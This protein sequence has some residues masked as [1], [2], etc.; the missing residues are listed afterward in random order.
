VL[1]RRRPA[2][3]PRIVSGVRRAAPLLALWPLPLLLRPDAFAGQPLILCIVLAACVVGLEACLRFGGA[4]VWGDLERR[5]GPA[6]GRLAPRLVA[7]AA[8]LATFVFGYA[9]AVRVHHKLLTSNFDF[10]LFENLFYNTL[11]GRHGIALA[12]P[13]FS[14][15]AEFLIYALLPFYAL[16]PRSETLFF[17]QSLLIVG[18][19]VPLYLL[20]ERWL[21]SAWSA[22]LLAL[23]YVSSP[24]LHGP[25][26]FDFHFLPLSAF[27]VLW[28]A[29]FWTRRRWLAFWPMVLLALCCREDVAIGVAAVG[30]GLALCGRTRRTAY[31]LLSLGVVWFGVVKFVWMPR[32]GPTSFSDYYALLIPPGEQ[33]FGAVVKT[34][35][36]NPLYTLSRT[37][38][39]DKLLLLLQLCAPLAFLPLRQWG[40]LFLLVPGTI[41][42]GLS[43][44]QVAI[45][46]IQF[47]YATHFL[48]YVFIAAV[49]GLAA[50]APR[51]RRVLWPPMLLGALVITLHFGAFFAPTFKTSFHELSFDYGPADVERRANFDALAAQIPERARLS[52]GEYEGAQL[53]RRPWLISI[54][55]GIFDADY[56]F[57]S[58]RSLRWGG[59]EGIR[60]ALGS[61]KYGVVGARGDLTLLA[62]GADTAHNPQAQRALIGFR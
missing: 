40:T 7:G 2:S 17:L 56:V 13:Y 31:A 34:L 59:A 33:G 35:L 27:F 16:V 36:S 53:A 22:A 49:L 51:E 29:W 62:R 25:L 9:R 28:A 50:R 43:T 52:S 19:A 3:A 10:G 38:S 42:V 60:Q 45:G 6:L 37:L 44:S 12:M 20:A 5:L 41:V 11:H 58:R 55:Q 18:A 15:H 39:A 1:S 30:V 57:Y 14:Q 32:Y 26:L 8:I 61:G 24:A 46:Q 4:P 48:P 54:K 21:R 23:I 47:H